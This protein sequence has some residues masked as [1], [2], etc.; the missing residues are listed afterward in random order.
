MADGDRAHKLFGDLLEPAH[1]AP[2]L[3][4]LHP[5]FQI[6]GNFGGTSGLTEL[7]L[8]SHDGEVHLLPAVPGAWP[9]GSVSGLR[10]RGAFG[11]DIAWAGGALASASLTSV[12]GNEVRLRCATPFSVWSGGAE[13]PVDRPEP[14]LAVF[15]TAEGTTYEIRSA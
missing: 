3:F 2:N 15:G 14:D 13:V 1:T 10:A 5:P 8:Q 9:A 12:A 4:D 7:L 6:D 11:V